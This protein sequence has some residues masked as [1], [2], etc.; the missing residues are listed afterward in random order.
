MAYIR[1]TVG[2]ILLLVS[3]GMVNIATIYHSLGKTLTA[4]FS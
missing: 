2:F 4:F 1:K 3:I